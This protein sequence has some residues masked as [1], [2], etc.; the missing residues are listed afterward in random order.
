MSSFLDEVRCPVPPH[1]FG[2]T[3]PQIDRI[4]CEPIR[5]PLG[6]SSAKGHHSRRIPQKRGGDHGDHFIHE[7]FAGKSADETATCFDQNI[8]P[9]VCFESR[10]QAGCDGALFTQ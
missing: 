7:A 4:E 6:G 3:N 1:E 5:N 10:G 8:G 9:S 2:I